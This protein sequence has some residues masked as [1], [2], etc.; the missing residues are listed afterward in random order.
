MGELAISDVQ[1]TCKRFVGAGRGELGKA[2]GR[3]RGVL[4]ARGRRRGGGLLR[5]AGRGG[6]RVDRQRCA[7]IRAGGHRVGRSAARVIGGSRSG[8]RRDVADARGARNRLG[9]DLQ[10]AQVRLGSVRGGRSADS[11]RDAGRAS[12][13]GPLGP[14]VSGV[15]RVLDAPWRGWGDAA[16]GGGV[17]GGR[18][19][20]SGQSRR[21]C[22]AAFPCGHGQPD[23]GR[24]ALDHA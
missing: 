4:R 18:V 23:P 13:R 19:R 7:G 8:D 17:R 22:P 3:A 24:R 21:R 5:H 1:R 14:R 11:R 2:H 10:P 16:G 6:R 20:A 9:C 15:R 12:N